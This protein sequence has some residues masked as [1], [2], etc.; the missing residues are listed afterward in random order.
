MPMKKIL[1]FI[2]IICISLQG[3]AQ[4]VNAIG[5]TVGVS[6]A[7]QNFYFYT[8]DELKLKKQFRFGPNASVFVEFFSHKYVRWVSEIQYNS[9][10][11]VDRQPPVKY[12]NKLSYICWNNYL[13]FRYE[14]FNIIPYVLVGPRLEYKFKQR[15]TSP[16]IVTSFAPLHVSP[17]VG[18]GIEFV[19]FGNIK[20]FVEGFY[21]PDW[22]KHNETM[23]YI[24]PPLH[25]QNINIE[26]RVG[27]KYQFQNRGESCN[28]PTYIE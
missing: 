3:K 17:A 15:T 14:L 9:K 8:P 7:K 10:G 26:L 2:I 20:F 28:T 5:V 24:T 23:A 27:L 21:N 22:K 12:K 25:V 19:S 11:S 16:P 13:K 6:A 1:V 4:F 18:A